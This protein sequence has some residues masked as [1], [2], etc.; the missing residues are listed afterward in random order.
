[1]TNALKVTLNYI[2]LYHVRYLRAARDVEVRVDDDDLARSLFGTVRNTVSEQY[3]RNTGS[4]AAV[5][6][7]KCGWGAARGG[8]RSLN[9]IRLSQP[10]AL[11]Y[12]TLHYIA[13]HY[14]ALH[15][16]T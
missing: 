16:V 11:H 15:Y 4:S 13:L 7:L 2:T 5:T 12:I 1:M 3:F 9:P 6:R 14:I 8:A 10:G